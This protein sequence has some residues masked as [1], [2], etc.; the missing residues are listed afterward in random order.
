MSLRKISYKEKFRIMDREALAT[1]MCAVIVT[2]AF[3]LAIFLLKDSQSTVLKMPLWFVVSCIG[4]Y[5]LSVVGV[6]YIVRRFFVNF[7]LDED[8]DD[9][10]H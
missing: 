7:D 3:W 8:T 9:A 5:L 2:L 4:G 10:N 1:V 6:I